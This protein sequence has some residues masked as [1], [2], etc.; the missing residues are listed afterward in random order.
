MV[1]YFLNLKIQ[2]LINILTADI[3]EKCLNEE[4]QEKL[5][6]PFFLPASTLIISF[7]F[8]FCSFF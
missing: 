1:W 5:W 4:I 7:L 3:S 6:I 2:H 8:S